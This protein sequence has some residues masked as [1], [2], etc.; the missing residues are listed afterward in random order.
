[1]GVKIP[2]DEIKDRLYKIFG[3]KYEYDFSNF[4]NTHSKIGV[5]CSVHG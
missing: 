2:L 3:Y 4:I 5:K 1:M